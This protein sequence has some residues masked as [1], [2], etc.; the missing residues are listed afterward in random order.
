MRRKRTLVVAAVAAGVLA[1]GAGAGIAR[2]AGGTDE[3]VTGPAA[4]KAAAAAVEAAGGG[5]AVEVEYQDGD[6]AGVYEVEVRRPDGTQLEVHLNGQFE[7]VGTAA[8]D[9]SC[10]ES[11][12]ADD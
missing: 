7:P 3:H 12:G 4:A 2:T 10:T 6:G 1:I 9:D 8:D 11:E 5:K